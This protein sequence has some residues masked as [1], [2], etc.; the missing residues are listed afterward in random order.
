MKRY[1]ILL[2]FTFFVCTSCKEDKIDL[3]GQIFIVTNG[4]QNLPLGLVVVGYSNLE[5]FKTELDSALIA[6]DSSIT[7]QTE[8]ISD[9]KK[10]I[11]G[12]YILKKSLWDDVLNE[13]KSI[14]QA[15]FAKKGQDYAL[16]DARPKYQF[17]KNWIGSSEE[18][19]D[20][21]LKREGVEY[22]INRLKL[23]SLRDYHSQL[24]KMDSMLTKL[25]KL[26]NL[27]E[28]LKNDNSIIEA[29]ANKYMVTKTNAQGEFLIQSEK[30]DHFIF[31]TSSRQVGTD[32]EKYM[33]C[34]KISAEKSINDLYL[35]NDNL[36]NVDDLRLINN[37]LNN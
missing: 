8:L 1:S 10:E 21:D 13:S 3:S 17:F 22:W 14:S 32:F 15:S 4:A 30:G 26:E 31:A 27:V 16:L 33:W 12:E 35:S 9:L 7:K 6:H 24:L 28:D 36:V 34:L 23:N 2:L 18:N 5:N 37:K 25:L 20:S 19:R 11:E 29:L